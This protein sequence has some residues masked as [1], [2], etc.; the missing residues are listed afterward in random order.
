MRAT[1]TLLAALLAGCAEAPAS[2]PALVQVVATDYALQVPATLAAGPAIITF[3]NRGAHRHE[4]AMAPL[5]P[6]LTAR[7]F[8]DSLAR[9]VSTASLRAKGSAVLF[10]DPQRRNDVVALRVT[11]TS[12][13]LWGV[14][15]QLRD[16]KDA[17]RH[18]ALG[19]V[20]V[21]TVP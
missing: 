11:L 1:E 13:E 19:M 10:A 6:G 12:G 8:A 5:K 16:G 20:A 7:Q 2:Q 9:G 15:C 4:L 18:T 17:P 3:E 21:V 14:W